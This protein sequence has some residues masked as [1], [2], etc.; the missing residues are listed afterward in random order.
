MKYSLICA[1][2]IFALTAPRPAHAYVLTWAQAETNLYDLVHD[3]DAAA[4][5]PGP[6]AIAAAALQ[7][8]EPDRQEA[9]FTGPVDRSAAAGTAFPPVPLGAAPGTPPD[10][11]FATQLAGTWH[12][13][14]WQ[15]ALAIGAARIAPLIGTINSSPNE[16]PGST[17]FVAQSSQTGF[18]DGSNLDSR[19][20]LAAASTFAASSTSTAT[21]TVTG[22]ESLRQRA[23]SG[24]SVAAPNDV[25]PL[26]DAS[27]LAPT[28]P[29]LPTPSYHYAPQSGPAAKGN[30]AAASFSGAVT[31]SGAA[32]LVYKPVVPANSQSGTTVGRPNSHPTSVE[33]ATYG[34]LIDVTLPIGGPANSTGA[35]STGANSTGANSTGA[36]AT[37]TSATGADGARTFL[38]ASVSANPT[39]MAARYVTSVLNAAPAS[40]SGQ[41]VE[42]FQIGQTNGPRTLD[43][44][45]TS[46]A[47]PLRGKIMAGAGPLANSLALP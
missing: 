8:A 25:Q 27:E 4:A 18:N 45:T 40:Q 43:G 5:T 20:R 34:R 15:K 24:F 30:L 9:G 39:A 41:T 38:P 10:N 3:G 19:R 26:P 14:A 23:G 7:T 35:N 21:M 22:P 44:P 33:A 32:A 31:A 6:M 42:A 46:V 29:V 13:N 17:V 36:N 11:D 1:T 16:K 12:W 2:S 47:D 37:E 28:T